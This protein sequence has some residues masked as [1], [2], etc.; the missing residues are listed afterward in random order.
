MISEFPSDLQSTRDLLTGSLRSH[1]ADHASAMPGDLLDDL[2]S[3]F[4]TNVATV[5]ATPTL[6]W[7]AKIQSLIARPSFGLAALAVVI[8]GLALPGMMAPTSTDSGF[9]GATV[10][11]PAEAIRIILIHAPSS[12]AQQLE[13]SGDFE[14]GA[15]SS[16]SRVDDNISGPRVLVNFE[17]SKISVINASDEV[18]HTA[19]IPADGS[20][21]SSAIA[22]AVSRL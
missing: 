8:L 19:A 14:R 18:I 2:L 15:I 11:A 4:Q 9:R 22:A 7:F 6:S 16:V 5:A 17:E 12:F 3:R 13:K 21:L 1:P 20:E 10:S